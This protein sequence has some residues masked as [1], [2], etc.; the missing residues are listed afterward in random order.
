MRPAFLLK[1]LFCSFLLSEMALAATYREAVRAYAEKNYKK[2]YKM[3]LDRAK[4]SRGK[5][6][7]EALIL[8]GAAAW[9][10]D[11][12]SEAQLLFATA[13]DLDRDADLPTVVKKRAVRRAFERARGEP[14]D[15]TA[16]RDEKIAAMTGTPATNVAA[17][18]S[19]ASILP[20]ATT[21][22]TV[23]QKADSP[24]AF[25]KASTY[26]PLGLNQIYQGKLVLGLAVGAVQTFAIT[27]AI[28]RNQVVQ[29]QNKKADDEYANA[30]ASGTLNE[31]D[32]RDFLD[33]NQRF[34]R[35]TQREGNIAIA[36]L[37]LTYIFSVFE[38]GLNPPQTFVAENDSTQ[39]KETKVAERSYNFDF[40]YDGK[41]LSGFSLGMNF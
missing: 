9:E 16:S 12:L 35:D 27:T 37:G 7:V 5:K 20:V 11:R 15:K 28:Q 39:E 29:E 4:N 38:A 41:R 1:I 34:V 36:V 24:Q 19:P 10:I 17:L 31:P 25:N 18:G 23:V 6:E 14:E 32:F 2:S 22:T 33:K 40:L 8:A 21:T 30:A 26:L 3:A 13:L